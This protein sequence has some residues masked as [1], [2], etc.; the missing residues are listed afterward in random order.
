MRHHRACRKR[1][2]REAHFGGATFTKGGIGV[3]AAH[4]AQGLDFGAPCT[5]A[6]EDLAKSAGFA[7]W[8][9]NVA[10][11]RVHVLPFI[12]E[13][14]R[15]GAKMVVIDPVRCATATIADRHLAIRPGSDALL[16]AGV[17]RLLIEQGAMT[18]TGWA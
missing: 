14:R 16:A 13:A 11:T 8:G 12:K 9:K 5:H 15:R 7:I 1:P 6:P 2:H 18:T 17:A 4:A 10:V 3:E